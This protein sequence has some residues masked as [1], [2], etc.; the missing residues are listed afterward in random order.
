MGP[1]YRRA[2]EAVTRV[3]G[4]LASARTLG[5]LSAVFAASRGLGLLREIGVA[6]YFGTSVAADQWAAAFAIASVV[7]LLVGEASY[8]AAVRWFAD[9]DTGDEYSRVVGAGARGGLA[10][11]AL[12][13]VAGPLLTLALLWDTQDAGQLSLLA[14]LLAPSV[15][16][17]V[18]ITCINAALTLEGR[19]IA[20][21]AAQALY[22][23][24]AVAGVLV[25]ALWGSE[26]GPVPIAIG[27]SAGTLLSLTLLHR[28][29]RPEQ[30]RATGDIPRPS[31][32]LSTGGPIA[33]AYFLFAMQEVVSRAIAA[34]LG[35]GNVAALSYAN[36]L[37]LLPLGFVVAIFGPMVINR[38]GRVRASTDPDDSGEGL[39]QLAVMGL[40]A[41]AGSIAFT[42]LGPTL[43]AACLAY[44]AFDAESTALT[45]DALDGFCIALPLVAVSLLFLRAIQTVGR[46]ASL[47]WVAC[48]ALVANVAA[49]I[50]LA[51]VADLYGVTLG[52]TAAAIMA[53]A[54]ELRVL[55]T[56]FG[57]AW[58]Y[59][60]SLAVALPAVASSALCATLITIERHQI[61]TDAQRVAGGLLGLLA[62]GIAAAMVLTWSRRWSF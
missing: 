58:M 45:T 26:L 32:F 37:Y 7:S 41:G 33:A 57:V 55:K 20:M 29:A 46:P 10:V 14:L 59:R 8:A 21:N 31:F 60:A 34:R 49:S 4:L 3:F 35:V 40:A 9:R 15:G 30:T 51:A 24:G 52:F 1:D 53:I 47:A 62:V 19:Y 28:I 56:A 18:P 12:F 43:I 44:G 11:A 38:F 2:T 54:L 13:S 50:P 42:A 5:A 39:D 6:V 61:I 27:W 17:M 25:I 36:R 48:G 22:S 23:A 16:A